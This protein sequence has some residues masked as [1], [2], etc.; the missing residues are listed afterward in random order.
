MCINPK[1]PLIEQNMAAGPK[2][3]E[4]NLQEF[5]KERD[6]EDYLDLGARTLGGENIRAY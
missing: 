4:V 6:V 5:D 2:K 1:P 3:S